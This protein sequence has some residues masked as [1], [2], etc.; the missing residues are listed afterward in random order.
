MQIIILYW[1]N[2]NLVTLVKILD[3]S[4]SFVI[5]MTLKVFKNYKGQSNLLTLFW[6]HSINFQRFKHMNFL[7]LFHLVERL[8]IK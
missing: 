3:Q 8:T 1:K 5:L 4:F 7:I 2:K 6:I